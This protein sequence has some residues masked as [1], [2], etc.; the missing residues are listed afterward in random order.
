M[1]MAL[2]TI[3]KGMYSSNRCSW[4]TF[5]STRRQPVTRSQ[6]ARGVMISLLVIIS[7][8]LIMYGAA[9]QDILIVKAGFAVTLV[10]GIILGVAAY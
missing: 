2:G 5:F 10:V 3:D 8:V 9:T 1:T 7:F 6:I 4:I